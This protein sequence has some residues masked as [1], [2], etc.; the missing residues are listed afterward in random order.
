[1]EIKNGE[2][3]SM[4]V[5]GATIMGTGGGGDQREGLRLLNEALESGKRL[6]ILP[7]EAMPEQSVI[8]APYF[9]GSVARGPRKKKQPV[10]ISEPVSVAVRQLEEVLGKRI[11]AFAAT[12]LG[13]L[14]TSIALHIAARLGLPMVDGDLIGRAGPELHQC[15]ANIFNIPMCPSAIVSKTGN[16]VVVKGYASID[17]YE[18]TARHQSVLAGDSAAVVDTPMTMSNAKRALVKGTVSLCYRLGRAVVE[19]RASGLD[20]VQAVVDELHGWK[21]FEG[22]VTRF[23]PKNEGGFLKAEASLEGVGEYAG[24]RLVSSI[25][26][27]HIMVWLDG[28]PAV[29]PPDLMSL[30]DGDGEAVTNG[31]LAVGM[32][33]TAVAA[34]APKVWRT[35]RGLEL[36]GPRHFGHDYDYVPVER[37]IR[38]K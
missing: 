36:F 32:R 24:H 6:R 34:R 30:L 18:R 28:K 15:T 27:E 1:M 29:M 13:G 38:R 33:L 35:K 31:Q 17:D 3:A 2:D 7:L 16:I 12:E 9:V 19:A 26:N 14:N 8:A 21:L 25:M 11:T 22:T 37:L 4:F 10:R 20:P 23:T 5:I